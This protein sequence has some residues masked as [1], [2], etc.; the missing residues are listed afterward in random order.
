MPV[1]PG[2]TRVGFI[3]LGLMGGP[4][5]G[6]V[7]RAG[8]ELHVYN[9]TQAKAESLLANG[10]IWHADPANLARA[11]DVVFTIVGFP[12]DVEDVYFGDAGLIAA[13]K[14]GSYVVDMS[15]SS[16]AL[17]R[18][19]AEAGRA[20]SVRVLDAPVTGGDIGAQRAQLSIMVGG[21]PA[22]F[23][24]LEPLF[25]CMGSAVHQGPSGFGQHAKLTN[26]IA[27][28]G[29]IVGVSEALGY[30]VRAGLD[31]EKL[32]QSISRGA[33]GS[34]L[35]VHAGP[36]MLTSDFAPGFYVKHFIKDLTLALESAQE[37]GLDARATALVKELY[38]RL[39]AQ[40]HA[41]EGTQAL[42]RLYRG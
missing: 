14:A 13:A 15:T 39:A 6:H 9:R 36:R 2:T 12:K 3:G 37:L 17:A 24:A 29:T 1:S 10:A 7:Q 31:G 25:R 34:A 32:L 27:I 40:G 42:F 18:R 38:D 30:A 35:L 26:Q 4:M 16:P 11:C 5:A 41:D 23:S 33:A 19:I 22:D 28:A 20:R 8:F 21:D